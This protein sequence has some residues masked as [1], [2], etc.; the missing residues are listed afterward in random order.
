[1]TD[2][3][4]EALQDVLRKL[5]TFGTEDRCIAHKP[6]MLYVPPALYKR[7]LRVLFYK[8][9]MRKGSGARKRKHNLYWRK[10]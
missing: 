7:A 8:K 2:L 5:H 1:M 6:K 10:V 3:T 4:L 9:P